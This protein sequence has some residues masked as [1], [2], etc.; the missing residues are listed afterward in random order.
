MPTRVLHVINGEF[1]AGA[2]RVRLAS[3]AAGVVGLHQE[4]LAW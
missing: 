2:E 1:Y 4:V 3:M